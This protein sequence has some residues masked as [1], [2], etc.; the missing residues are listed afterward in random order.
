MDV[1]TS[2]LNREIEKDVHIEKP[3]VF[4]VHGKESHVCI[5]KKALYK[6]KQASRTWYRWI[7]GHFFKFGFTKT[8]VDSK[9]YYKVFDGE[10]L[11]LV[12]YVDDLYLTEDEKLIECCNKKLASKFDMKDLGQLHYFLGLEIRHQRDEI[13]LSQGKYN[14]NILG[15]F[16]MLDYKSMTTLMVTNLNKLHSLAHGLDLVDP[17]MYRQLTHSLMYLVNTRTNILFAVST[18]SQFMSEMREVH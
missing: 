2:F 13:F 3:N 1:K 17:T 14:V 8:D 11:I 10:S 12:L 4:V 6:L 5:L 18:L 9:L 15:R 7:D 16:G